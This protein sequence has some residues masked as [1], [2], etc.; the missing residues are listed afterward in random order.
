[1]TA[2]SR[3]VPAS[4]DRRVRDRAGNRCEYCGIAQ[5]GQEATFHVDHVQPRAAGGSTSYDNLALAC[6]SCSLRKGARTEA[7]DPDTRELVPVFSPRR[8][9]WHDN[10]TV[11]D[12]CVIVGLTPTG[13]ATVDALQMNRLL[14]VAIRREERARGRY[15]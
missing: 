15:P 13:S 7:T 8:E 3:H 5:V 12:A 11:S 9:A 6:V 14:A 1:V 2:S 4:L 10:F